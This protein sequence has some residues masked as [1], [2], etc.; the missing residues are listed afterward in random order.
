MHY[1]N[2]KET[3]EKKR[4]IVNLALHAA[5]VVYIVANIASFVSGG[6]S[7]FIL[8]FLQNLFC[9]RW[10]KKNMYLKKSMEIFLNLLCL[11]NFKVWPI[12]A[13]FY[14]ITLIKFNIQSLTKI[15]QANMS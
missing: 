7:W 8:S 6:D 5:L 2:F 15:I 14:I 4:A 10:F 11:S 9:S 3:D 1:I 13:L 12:L